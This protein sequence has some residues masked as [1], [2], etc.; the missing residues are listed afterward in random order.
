MTE[1]ERRRRV[2]A[3]AHEHIARLATVS[4]EPTLQDPLAPG[5]MEHR[6]CRTRQG[7]C[8]FVD[9]MDRVEG[10]NRCRRTHRHPSGGRH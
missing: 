4:A 2:F 9:R 1:E 7:G 6:A 10:R 5:P 8:G 3:E